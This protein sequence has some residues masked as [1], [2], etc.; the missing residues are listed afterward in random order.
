MKRSPRRRSYVAIVLATCSTLLFAN[1]N[2][3]P[4]QLVAFAENELLSFAARPAVVA[5][6]RTKN[7]SGLTI[8]ETKS[9]DE[10]WRSTDGISRFMLDLMGNDLALELHNLE[11][12]YPFIVETFAMDRLGGNAAQT[13]RTSDYWQGDE[14]KFT[15]SFADGRGA[16]HYGE[17]EYDESAG[18]I[19]VQV[20]VPVMDGSRA[21]GAI[22]FSISLDRWE[23]R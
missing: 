14:A 17:I 6:I 23:R 15:R 16:I 2:E 4:T 8:E 22:T 3:T 12:R 10:A 7:A 1:A 19:V 13:E 9:I 21:I 5:A 18:E 11:H 20:S